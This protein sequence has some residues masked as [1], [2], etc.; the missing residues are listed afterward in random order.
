[1]AANTKTN[2]QGNGKVAATCIT[3]YMENIHNDLH[4][5]TRLIFH[6]GQVTVFYH[7]END[8]DAQWAMKHNRDMDESD[9][10]SYLYRHGKFQILTA[11]H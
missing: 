8:T 10:K 2:L 7:R 11:Q 6:D 5:E 9:G 4:T 1:M 3:V